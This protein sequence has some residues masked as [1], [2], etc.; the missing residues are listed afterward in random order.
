MNIVVLDG[1]TLNPGDLSWAPLQSLGHCE[2][3]DRTPPDAVV[4][5]RRFLMVVCK[6]WCLVQRMISL[7]SLLR[8]AE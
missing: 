1:Y 8:L 2:I 5:F 4:Q 6:M 3:Y 7:R